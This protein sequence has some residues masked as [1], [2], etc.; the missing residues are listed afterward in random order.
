MKIFRFFSNIRIKLLLTYIILIIFNISL[1]GCLFYYF[2][3]AHFLETRKEYLKASCNY[4][5]QFI[6]PNLNSAEDLLPATRFFIR[7]YWE[8]MDYDFVVI[9]SN[10]QIISDTRTI[11]DR[12]G[13]T[14]FTLEKDTILE[15]VLKSGEEA[16][17]IENL[18]GNEFIY[19]YSPITFDNKIIGAVK[20]IISTDDFIA[21]YN[22]LKGYFITTFFF[23]LLAAIM[24]AILFIKTLMK[25]ISDVRNVALDITEGN[26]DSRVKY[27]GDDEIADLSKNINKMAE[28]LKMLEQTR[29]SF[30]ANVSHE[31]RTPLTIIKGFA[32]TLDG[33]P[34]LGEE[35]RHFVKTINKEADRLTRLVNELLQLSRIRTGRFSLKLKKISLKDLI[36]SVLFQMKPKAEELSCEL[37]LIEPKEQEGIYADS[38]RIR[39]VLIN[40]LD[41]ALKYA[42]TSDGESKVEIGYSFDEDHAMIYVSD[43]GPGISEQETSMLFERFFRGG[44]RTQKVEGVG[45]GLAIAKEIIEAHGGSI[46]LDKTAQTG[47]KFLI[48]L[49][50]RPE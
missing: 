42:V 44:S 31:L 12:T 43:N 9:D 47:C 29:N 14:P 2:T 39:E 1:M 37:K 4:Y 32:M 8:Q 36:D 26:L 17:R 7:H 49:P 3:R 46:K 33:D 6:T 41:N 19:Q 10:E 34:E 28:S 38:D 50:I 5:I 18:G 27:K 21:M 45:L 25:P 20:F 24:L 35:N 11:D 40:L 30:L 16:S 15:N 48:Q 23:S 13:I 22:V